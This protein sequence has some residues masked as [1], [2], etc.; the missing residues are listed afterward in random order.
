[1]SG[2][3]MASSELFWRLNEFF[4]CEVPGALPVFQDPLMFRHSCGET[5]HRLPTH[6]HRWFSCSAPSPALWVV[7][8][9]G[10]W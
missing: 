1:M 4:N 10:D 6:Q 5:E 3:K 8:T 9:P 7:G 2:T